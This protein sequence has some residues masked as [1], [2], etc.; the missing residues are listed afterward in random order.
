LQLEQA[1]NRPHYSAASQAV[2][3]S[4]DYKEFQREHEVDSLGTSEG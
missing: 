3:A 4:L 1:Q 2:T